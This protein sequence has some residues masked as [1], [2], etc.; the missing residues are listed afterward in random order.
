[1]TAA[2]HTAV[3]MMDFDR[4]ALGGTISSG[5]TIADQYVAW[6]ARWSPNAWSGTGWATNTGMTATRTD[7]GS[8]YQA[9]MLNVLHAYNADWQMENGDASMALTFDLKSERVVS[10]SARFVGDPDG[11]SFMSAYHWNGTSY[12]LLGT[13]TLGPNSGSALLTITGF[14][15]SIDRVAFAVGNFDDWVALDDVEFQTVVPEPG[16]GLAFLLAG[17]LLKQRGRSQRDRPR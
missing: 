12:D 7:V 16:F 17:F 4:D 13:S 1:M 3:R 15:E 14:A 11:G 5:S 10:V 6:G 2:G 9:A 8:G